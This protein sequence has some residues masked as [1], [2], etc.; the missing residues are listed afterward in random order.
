[1]STTN[2]T[3]TLSRVGPGTKVGALFRSVWLPALLSSQLREP[4]GSPVRLKLLGE[5]LVAFRTKKGEVGITQANCAH[6]L[7]PLYYGRVE[8]DGIRCNY[9]GWLYNSRGQ[10]LEMQ[11]EPDSAI[12]SKVKI[13]A[14]P[15][16]E[17]A[18]IVWIYMGEGEAPEL[19]KFPWIDL[20]KSQRNATVW[21]QESNWLQGMEGELDSS[22]VSILHTNP[23]TLATSPVHRPYSAVDLTPK[24]YAKDTPIG[25]LGV[26]RRNADNQYY[27]RVSQFMVPAFS[28]IP[29]VDFPVG[30][31]AFIPIDDYNTYTWDFNYYSKGDLPQDFLDYTGKGLA[32]PPESNYQ[33]YRLNTGTIIDAFVP[34][35]TAE[36]NYLINRDGGSLSS[37]SGIHG[38]NDQDRAMQEGMLATEGSEGRIVDREKEFLVATDIAIVR[39]RRRILNIVQSEES[40]EQF[41]QTIKD[42]TAYSVE[43]LDVLSQIEDV[44]GFVREYQTQL[45][46]QK[47]SV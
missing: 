8:D 41:R 47:A 1:M 12:C 18:D 6:R 17:K 23:A 26:A 40:L 7:A 19:P 21:I 20:P 46:P 24:L 13:K 28:S 34:V 15:V 32:F 3:D 45:G 29:S 31:R 10:C 36:N 38:L 37:P 14:Y 25:I 16:V 39:A 9:H 33:S 4:G 11:N 44:D 2:R 43:P 27:W 30:G 22:H 5:E 42:G 35:R